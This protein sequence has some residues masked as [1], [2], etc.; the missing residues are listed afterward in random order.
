MLRLN[1]DHVSRKTI[2]QLLAVNV[3]CILM[4]IAL[5]PHMLVSDIYQLA[6]NRNFEFQFDAVQ[7]G[8]EGRLVIST[9]RPSRPRCTASN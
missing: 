1:Q 9:K 4:D 6:E 8:L 5:M 2:L 3:S 7:R